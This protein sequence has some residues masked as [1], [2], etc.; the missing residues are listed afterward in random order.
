MLAAGSPLDLHFSGSEPRGPTL[1]GAL[2]DQT[3]NL[4][5]LFDCVDEELRNETQDWRG[6]QQQ[7][8]TQRAPSE[9]VPG[10]GRKPVWKRCEICAGGP[11]RQ[12]I[13]NQGAIPIVELQSRHAWVVGA[14]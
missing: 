2:S 7:P 1:E 9:S 12:G 6:D 3:G 8:P 14:T 10:G 13:A 4:K 5:R 11:W